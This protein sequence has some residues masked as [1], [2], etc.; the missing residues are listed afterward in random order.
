MA[1]RLYHLAYELRTQPSNLVQL[2]KERGLEIPSVLDIMD[3]ETAERA[4]RVATGQE[5]IEATAPGKATELRL[6]PPVVPAPK[7]SLR[8]R[9]AATT[10]RRA[11][12]RQPQSPRK[13]IRIF[14]Q[15]EVRERRVVDAAKAEEAFTGRTI[16][17]TVPLT[18]K[19]LSQQMGV[20]TNDL[21]LHLMRQKINANLNMML[22]EETV[23]VLAEAFNRTVEIQHTKTVEQEL[24]QLLQ[25]TGEEIAGQETVRRP[26]VVAV[27]GHVDHGKTTLLD[28]IRKARVAAGEV[29]GITQHIGAYQ[30]KTDD[31]QIITFL[32]TPGHEAFTAMRARGAKITDIVIL[33]IAAD[34]GVMP[35]TEEA[36]AHAK[37]AGV[38]IIVAINKVDRPD[39][40]VERVKQQLSTH[41]L[42]PEEWG[43]TTGVIELSALK[44]TGVPALLERIALEAELL[45]LNVNPD[46]NAEG[47]VVE[48]SKQAGQGVVANLLVLKGTLL[49]GDILLAGSCQGKVKSLHDDRGHVLPEAGPSMPAQVTGLDDVPEA[50]W[51][52]Q[53]VSDP[54]IA[55][56]VADDRAQRLRATA[57]A[58]R[59]HVTLENLYSTIKN[60]Q[61][62]ELRIVLKTDVKGS[63][64]AVRG[65]LEEIGTDEIRVKILHGAVGAINES[66]IVLADASD[67]VVLGFHVMP[68]AKARAAAEKAGVQIRTYQIIYELLDGVHSAVEGMLAP[69]ITENVLGHAEVREV[70]NIRKMGKIAGCFMTDGLGRRD[71]KVRLVRDGAVIYNDGQIDSL[72]RF[73]DDVKEVKEGFECGIRIAGYDDV[74]Q[75]DVI[76]FFELQEQ[77]RTL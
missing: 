27:L 62:E 31:G 36:L 2:L 35:Q 64:E 48:A 50:G 29:G 1:I 45:D 30:T 42:T 72:R 8:P 3:D 16:P 6:P 40:N 14:R 46:A 67:A 20:K 41:E 9:P 57:L 37:A 26:P 51:P 59:S 25:D 5:T 76:E 34:D 17:V 75:G 24:E 60:E 39:A 68:E 73:K 33:I 53:T 32:D 15:K 38:P 18:L 21:L 66:D 49:R 19:D 58:A 65:K 44:G 23:L 63:L 52:F 55:R 13:G 4:R 69:E 11:T 71:S 47:F 10:K 77:K 43:G 28:F 74:K 12:E 54:E 22:D 70:F 61:V 7:R 56:K